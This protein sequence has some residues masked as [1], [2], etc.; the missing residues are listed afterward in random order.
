MELYFEL[1]RACMSLIEARVLSRY[2][3]IR[4]VVPYCGGALP[5]VLDRIRTFGLA[6]YTVDPTTTN[7]QVDTLWYDCAGAPFP[8]HMAALLRQAKS[9]RIVYGSESGSIATDR[10]HAHLRSLE[11]TA[12]PT[13][14]SW[15]AT[16]VETGA[17]LL[18]T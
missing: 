6:G 16:L 9:E 18:P 3:K 2:P 14:A 13:H 7:S 15:R 12:S 8:T 17:A 4:V 11:Q 10:V 1:V 5:V